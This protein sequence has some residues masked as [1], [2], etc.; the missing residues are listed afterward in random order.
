[1]IENDEQRFYLKKLRLSSYTKI[2][3][4]FQGRQLLLFTSS[5]NINCATDKN[6]GLR[7]AEF[8]AG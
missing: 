5:W 6:P 7:L 3:Q 1:M 4:Y 2:S 8:S